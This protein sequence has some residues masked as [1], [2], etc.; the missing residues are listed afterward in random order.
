ML[1]AIGDE[2]SIG[3]RL[4]K[5]R[6][7]MQ[8]RGLDAYIVP[9]FDAHQGEYCAAHDERLAW[10]TGFTG[11]AGLG[12]V[13]ADAA[14]L[15]V[16][17]RYSVQVREQTSSELFGYEHLIDAP[18][19]QWLSGHAAE[20]WTVGYD[21]MLLPASWVERFSAGAQAAGA[22]LAVV[23]TNLVDLIWRDQPAKPLAA[24]SRLS[25]QVAG[26]SS[27]DKR[28]RIGRAL[29]DKGVDWLV[30]T[31]PDA[32]AWLL[33]ARGGDVPYNPVPH[34]FA[35]VGA[36]GSVRWFV[37]QQK[38]P[39]GTE[40][41]GFDD[42]VFLVPDAFLAELEGLVSAGQKVLIDPDFAPYAA[43]RAVEA[44]G[45]FVQF[46]RGP[47][48]LA[49]A[50]KNKAELAG[51]AD[52]CKRDSVAWIHTLAWLAGS[53][54]PRAE[55][56]EPITELEVVD[57]ILAE[58]QKL[59]G[60]SEPSFRTIAAADSNGAMCHYSVDE[61]SNK[62]L[63][64]TSIFLLD[65]GGQFDC[66]TT[67]ATRTMAFAPVSDAVRK[68]YSLVLKGHIRLAMLAFP[69][70]TRG[71]HIDVIARQPLWQHGMDYD[72]GTGHGVGHVLCVHEG[73]QR[74]AKPVSA[75]DLVPGM[76][77]SNE[78]GYYEAGHYG[79]R[80]ENLVEIVRLD[81]GYMGFQD[82]TLVPIARELID[83]ALLDADEIAW[84]NAYHARVRAEMGDLVEDLARDWLRKNTEPISH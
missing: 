32:I 27:L 50:V 59:Q 9:R 35:I 72:H 56:G 52:A 84:L 38:F 62:P 70:G 22:E 68:A 74:I 11:S 17:G 75:F 12:L 1:V 65:S 36:D 43:V 83:P 13:T 23:D 76:I 18:L 80:I 24:I 69:D 37:D 49:K 41:L 3:E 21:A 6:Q 63:L 77:V 81:N 7:V 60:F 28:V 19:E 14:L 31:Q 45:G 8:E 58:R 46:E 5:L 44:A 67:D 78:P 47:V 66:G 34:S 40:G 54:V 79:I 71:H 55:A 73:P 16:D 51:M 39:H 53:V 25:E 57:Y 61:I 82:L 64:E 26:E 4:A 30:E 33:N 15:F 20:G 42:I 10:L 48:A 2:A 29:A